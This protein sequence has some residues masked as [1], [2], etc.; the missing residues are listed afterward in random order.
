MF[1]SMS[2]Q[3]NGRSI[4]GIVATGEGYLL[5]SSDGERFSFTATARGVESKMAV[6]APIVAIG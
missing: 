4:I 3:T 5:A 2:G 6:D 1:G